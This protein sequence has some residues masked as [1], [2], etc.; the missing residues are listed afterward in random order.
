MGEQIIKDSKTMNPLALAR[1]IAQDKG[2]T[3]RP[4]VALLWANNDVG[5]AISREVFGEELMPTGK[6]VDDA[7]LPVVVLAASEAASLLRTHAW[8]A[9]EFGGRALEQ[10]C[11][12]S[13]VYLVMCEHEGL[14]LRGF[15]PDD[16]LLV[17][18]HLGY[19]A[20]RTQTAQERYD[21]PGPSHVRL[22]LEDGS[23]LLGFGP[24]GETAFWAAILASGIVDGKLEVG[25]GSRKATIDLRS[26]DQLVEVLNGAFGNAPRIVAEALTALKKAGKERA[27]KRLSSL[28]RNRPGLY[29]L[30]AKVKLELTGE[31]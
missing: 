2:I 6:S 17:H 25:D 19:H 7:A 20:Q 9:G 23:T 18:Y 21:D 5:S 14:V 22:L 31:G 1:E 13:D 8:A 10:N 29:A 3:S 28:L 16:E 27:H 30:C 15:G 24:D 12:P 4:I 26:D 11:P